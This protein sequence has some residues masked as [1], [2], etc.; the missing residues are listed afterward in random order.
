MHL[1]N[2]FL[3]VT[4][5][6]TLECEH[7]LRG[8]RQRVNMDNSVLESVFKDVKKVDRLLLTGGEPLLAI[9]TLERLTEMIYKGEIEVK[10]ITLITNGTVLSGRV[11]Y[12]LH[13]LQD[14]C[15]LSLKL[16]TDIFHEIELKKRNLLDLRNRNLAIYKR[17]GF[18]DF[19]E[20]STNEYSNFFTSLTN[21]GRCQRLTP[22][23]LEQING[24][25]RRQYLINT[26][27]TTTHPF[28]DIKDDYVTGNISVDVNGNLISY[29]L[30][31]EEEDKEA[32]ESGINVVDMGCREAINAF[33]KRHQES[34]AATV[35]MMLN[36][37]GKKSQQV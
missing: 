18:F 13:E 2:L 9:Q 21:K 7:C 26:I 29:G 36:M 32:Y 37:T 6:C 11:L 16:S 20:Y 33:I 35:K 17:N 10:H 4:R 34:Y 23:R 15:E 3:E 5:N 1:E 19:S 24:M 12:M 31:F 8:D 27:A 30:S 28:T 22:E 14:H 25:S